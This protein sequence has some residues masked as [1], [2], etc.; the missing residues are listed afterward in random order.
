MALVPL[1]TRGNYVVIFDFRVKPGTGGDFI[2][3][4]N[5][6]DYSDANPFRK[7][8]ARMKDG[9]LCRDANDPDHFYAIGEW[10][11][12]EAHM[13]LGKLVAEMDPEFRHLVA[14][15]KFMATYAQVVSGVPGMDVT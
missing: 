1:A 8:S 15:G 12:I 11:D 7:S 14:D 5:A 4:F 9:V 13:R 3:R 2:G 10:S 6:F